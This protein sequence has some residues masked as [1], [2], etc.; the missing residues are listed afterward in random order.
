MRAG[1]LEK[2]MMLACGEG[3]GRRERPKKRGMKEIMGGT[4][5]GLEEL[6]EVVRNRSTCTAMFHVSCALV[7]AH[8]GR[9]TDAR[10]RK[11]GAHINVRNVPSKNVFVHISHTSFKI[12][13]SSGQMWHKTNFLR[14]R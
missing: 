14:T 6:R 3:G 4:G 10:A 8:T 9:E 11:P 7:R 13:T 1:G 12:Q 2:E 5:M